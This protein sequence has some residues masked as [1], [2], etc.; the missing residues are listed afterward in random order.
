M[1][2]Q[3]TANGA[4]AEAKTKETTQKKKK[5]PKPEAEIPPEVSYRAKISTEDHSTQ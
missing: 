4:L 3:T 1:I 5:K 2:D